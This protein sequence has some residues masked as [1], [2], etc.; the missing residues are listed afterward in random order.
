MQNI[1]N[2]IRW[3]NLLMIAFVQLLV[4]YALFNSLAVDTYLSPIN[5]TLLILSTLCIAA[6]GY[7]INDIYDVETDTINK[8]NLVIIGKHISESKANTLYMALTFIGV[9]IG[10]YLANGIGRPKFFGFFVIIAALLY[11]YSTSLK[12]IAVVGNIIVSFLVAS[13]ILIVGI[14]EL[15]PAINEQ[16]QNLQST[17][18]EVLADFGIF[19]FLLNFIREIVKDIQDVDGD[20]KS[21]MQTLPIIL[22]KSRTA[23]IAFTLT[24]ITIAII[25]FYV[26]KYLFMHKEVVIYFLIMV[27]GPLIYTAIKLFTAEKN[28][29]FKH[30]SFIL[31][32]T[33]LTGML[34]MVLYWLIF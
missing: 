12:Q 14:F 5:F 19:A 29:E 7:I 31:K 13:S 22:G 20:Y 18:F 26:T 4:K 24:L 34:V 3:K 1:L 16:N 30:I 15:L 25:I 33:M 32:L 11:V 6:G 27:V 8:P 9:I 17:M 21:G 23:K 10:F 28:S 2:L